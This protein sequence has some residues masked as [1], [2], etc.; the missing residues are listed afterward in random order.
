M[1]NVFL[2]LEFCILVNLTSQRQNMD[3]MMDEK[4]IHGLNLFLKGLE[5]Y[6][7]KESFCQA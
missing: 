6:P 4:I 5:L 2:D 7:L 3:F 1:K